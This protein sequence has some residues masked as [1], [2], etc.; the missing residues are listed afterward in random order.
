MSLINKSAPARS[1]FS[2]GLL[3]IS[4]LL[5]SSCQQNAYRIDESNTGRNARLE[6]ELEDIAPVRTLSETVEGEAV[7]TGPV[8]VAMILPQ[9]ASGAAGVAGTEIANAAKL[10]MQD[11]AANRFQLVIKDTKGQPAE[12]SILAAQARDEGASLVLGPLFSANVSSASGVTE[13]AKIPMIAFSSDVA[14]ARP[15]VYLL[16]FP[17]DVDIRRTLS[18]GF[19]LGANKVVA[20][21]PESSYGR[22]AE[23]ELK[24]A[25]NELGGQIVS[26]I[27]YPRDA[28]AIFTAAQSA[29]QPLEFANAI[30]I[31]E[32]GRVPA[33]ILDTLKNSG[34]DLREKQI[35]GS[36]QWTS[37]SN[38]ESVLNGAI[39]AGADKSNMGQFAERYKTIYGNDPTITAA[40][41]YDAISLTAELLKRDATAPFSASQIQS[42]GGFRGATGIFRFE[43]DGRLQ[44][45]LVVN[46]LE[47]GQPVIVSPAPVSFGP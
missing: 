42:R 22:L 28:D 5:L 27:R 34:V 26:I 36:G 38:K 39:F 37:T 44:R 35:M 16:S 41:G 12:A 32:G 20:L 30:Y 15:G 24:R 33:L 3:V 6:A 19:S 13:P 2:R 9:S 1:V 46:R 45:A 4:A 31:P 8:R 11:F 21:L 25:Y 43:A 23:R 29:V 7:G 14:R 17:P 10:A 40:L 47:Q 18:Y